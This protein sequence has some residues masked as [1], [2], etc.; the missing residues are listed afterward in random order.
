M[1]DILSNGLAKY[2][3]PNGNT[4]IMAHNFDSGMNTTHNLHATRHTN[5]LIN[6]FFEP[7]DVLAS[8][9]IID[10]TS[11][12]V[13][14]TVFYYMSDTQS[15]LNNN[16]INAL[17]EVLSNVWGQ[18]VELRLVKLHYPY[19]NS[20][21]LAA[22]IMK[23]LETDRFERVINKIFGITTPVVSGESNLPSHIIGI[24]IRLAG[25]LVTEP[26]RPRMTV[27]SA[28]IGSFKNSTRTIIEFGQCTS[29]NKKGALTVQV[30]ISQRSTTPTHKI[31]I[32]FYSY[33]Y[34]INKNIF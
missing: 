9:P 20:D 27:Q 1:K 10:V 13:T 32:R 23:N 22:F 29:V 17:G 5:T 16:T 8:K 18:A 2:Y 19:L 26:S 3:L 7:I 24:K 25:R 28:Q 14:V 12:T 15:A 30:W 4:Q 6:Q 33:S 31:L 21:I 11:T 34:Y